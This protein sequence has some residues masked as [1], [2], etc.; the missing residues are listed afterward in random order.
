MGEYSATS[1]LKN[2]SLLPS[3]DVGLGLSPEHVEFIP[4]FLSGEASGEGIG[5]GVDPAGI[6]LR[7][8]SPLWQA[9]AAWQRTAVSWGRRSIWGGCPPWGT[10]AKRGAAP[11]RPPRTSTASTRRERSPTLRARPV[12]GRGGSFKAPH[13]PPSKSLEPQVGQ[14]YQIRHLTCGPA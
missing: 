10:R 6:W 1:N 5:P 11:S 2:F 9:A 13:R 3:L 4:S 8:C 7:T 12:H 14:H